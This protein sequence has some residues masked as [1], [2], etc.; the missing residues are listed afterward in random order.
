MDHYRK[1]EQAMARLAE[2]EVQSKQPAT[3]MSL[4]EQRAAAYAILEQQL[5]LSP[6]T[7]AKEMPAF[8]LQLYNRS[9]ANVLTRAQAAYALNHFEEAER[10]SVEAAT[11]DQRAYAAAQRAQDQHRQ[12]AFRAFLLAGQSAQQRIQVGAKV[13]KD[14]AQ[15]RPAIEQVGYAT[16]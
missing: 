8:A 14:R 9:D 7:L 15:R 4:E 2:V 13:T 16:Q 11:T 3:K 1:M 12:G 5:N 10:L 6:G